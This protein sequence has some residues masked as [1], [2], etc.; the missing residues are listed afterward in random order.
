MSEAATK[1]GVARLIA[2]MEKRLTARIDRLHDVVL[3]NQQHHIQQQEW[4][5]QF[6]LN[7]KEFAGP[8]ATRDRR[9]VWRVAA[10]FCYA[11][12]TSSRTGRSH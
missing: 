8:V 4:L 9:A 10:R 6:A 5:L 2:E 1:E 11:L 3:Q 7:A 12:T